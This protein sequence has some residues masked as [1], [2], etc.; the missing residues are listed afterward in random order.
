MAS[1]AIASSQTDGIYDLITEDQIEG[2]DADSLQQTIDQSGEP[3]WHYYPIAEDDDID[4][5]INNEGLPKEDL[6]QLLDVDRGVPYLVDVKSAQYLRYQV[7]DAGR[8]KALEVILASGKKIIFNRNESGDFVMDVVTEPL[9][10]KLTRIDGVIKSNFYQSG[11][12]AGLS[13]SVIQQFANIFQWQLNFSKDLRAGDRFEV[14]LGQPVDGKPEDARILAASLHQAKKTLTAIQ[15]TD[16]QF[17][18]AEGLLLGSSFSRL[19]VGDKYRISSGFNPGRVH[20]VTGKRRPHK[21][22][23]WAV[24]TG[25][26]VMA[27]ADG[28]VV[29][30]VRNHPAAGNYIEI[31][32]SRRYVT[33]FLHLDSLNV[34]AGEQIK[35]GQVI[36]LS[37]NTGISTG[38]HLHYEMYVNGRAV[39]AMKVKL[40][41]GKPLENTA[42]ARF[43]I[44][45]KPLLA[46]LERDSF[47]TMLARAPV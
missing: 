17:Y 43:N 3:L 32:N 14:L 10:V 35:K 21:G 20:P 5:I 19:P 42:L 23:D 4:S 24:P 36:A 16:G 45:S 33:R 2:P 46:L 9:N 47:T 27:T 7:G 44:W 22:T 25:T 31:R 38:P 40:P 29:K 11:K 39:N 28:V 6:Q 26:P 8:V 13:V 1:T 34:K 41:D 37:G 30:A 15:N 18:S 12:A